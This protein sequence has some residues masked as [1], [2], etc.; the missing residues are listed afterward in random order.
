M[1][2]MVGP[3]HYWNA[4]SKE[5]LIQI[6]KDAEGEGFC[7]FEETIAE[8]KNQVIENEEYDTFEEFLTEEKYEWMRDLPDETI[9]YSGVGMGTRDQPYVLEKP[10]DWQVFLDC[11]DKDYVL[12]HSEEE[13]VKA[14]ISGKYPNIYL[15]PCLGSAA[16]KYPHIMQLVID[17]VKDKFMG[18]IESWLDKEEDNLI[19]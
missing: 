1:Y 18:F 17:E 16:R 7:L 13:A 14:F 11:I 6:E 3:G 5:Q 10:D 19:T 8:I 12:F 2:F 4:H 15:G 9:L